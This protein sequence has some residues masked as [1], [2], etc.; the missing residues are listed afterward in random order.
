MELSRED[1]MIKQL[2]KTFKEDTD[3]YWLNTLQIPAHL[4]THS[5]KS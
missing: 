1:K 2:C 3:S 4:T 5:A